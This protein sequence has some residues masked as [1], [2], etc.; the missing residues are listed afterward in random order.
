MHPGSFDQFTR[1][2][3]PFVGVLTFAHQTFQLFG[4]RRKDAA[5]RQSG[6]VTAVSAQNIQR[7]GI[8][9]HR[10][11]ARFNQLKQ[12][13]F[14]L[15]RLPQSRPYAHSLIIVRIS[16]RGKTCIAHVQLGHG[17]GYGSLHNE[18][19][20]KRHM[21]CQ[22]SYTR[23]QTS[24]CRQNRSSCHSLRTGNQQGMPEVS[25]MSKA[26]TRLQQSGHRFAFCQII[27]RLHLLHAFFVKPYVQ[28]L[29]LAYKRFVLRKKESQLRQLQAQG[30]IGTDDIRLHII[31]VILSHQSRWDINGHHRGG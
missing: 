26:A 18:L 11:L 5:L 20:A 13:L 21:Q 14:S 30:Q 1:L 25:F 17:F 2:H 10:S 23:T 9:Y 6:Y 3:Q 8:Y 24:L 4:M 27:V 22:Q 15:R 31:A 7:V 19:I 16:G 29:P 12:S 28:Q